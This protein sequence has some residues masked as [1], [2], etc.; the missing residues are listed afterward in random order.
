MVVKK[1]EVADNSKKNKKFTFRKDILYYSLSIL[2]IVVI[3]FLIFDLSYVKDL[4]KSNQNVDSNMNY[5][6]TLN[7]EAADWNDSVSVYYELYVDGKLFQSNFDSNEP[8]E[9]VLGSG[10]AIK[11]FERQIVGMDINETKTFMVDPSEGYGSVKPKDINTSLSYLMMLVKQQTGKEYDANQ[12]IGAK[13]DLQ[14]QTCVVTSTLAK[15]DIITLSCKNLLA[16]KTLTFK[17]K[18]LDIRTP[19]DVNMVSSED[20]NS[21][22]L[23]K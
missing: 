8:F 10:Q 18:L 1:K 13:F 22:D 2:A 7:T 17:V 9:F 12:L 15:E 6:N 5:G 4:S 21:N 16:D 3:A 14:S 23:N 11:G 20:S 19:K